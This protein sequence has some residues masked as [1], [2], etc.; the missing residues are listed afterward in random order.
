MAIYE[1]FAKWV[2]DRRF[3][4]LSGPSSLLEL[5]LSQLF[6]CTVRVGTAPLS[7]GPCNMTREKGRE[8]HG[9]AKSRHRKHAFSSL[10]DFARPHGRVPESVVIC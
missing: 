7:L 10:I 5:L 2:V 3:P 6:A 8:K 1:G 4:I 9:R